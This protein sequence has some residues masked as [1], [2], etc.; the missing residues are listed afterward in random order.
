MGIISYILNDQGELEDPKKQ[1][2]NVAKYELQAKE[3]LVSTECF[4]AHE[5]VR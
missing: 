5:L 2:E 1:A 3:G 4:G